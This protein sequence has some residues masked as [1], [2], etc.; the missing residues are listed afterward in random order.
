MLRPFSTHPVNQ[1][2]ERLMAEERAAR[3][4]RAAQNQPGRIARFLGILVGVPPK[5]ARTA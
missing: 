2:F 4:A 5:A 3:A 1:A